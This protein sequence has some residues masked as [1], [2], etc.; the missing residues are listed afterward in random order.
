MTKEFN[1][2]DYQYVENVLTFDDWLR[3][4]RPQLN[5]FNDAARFD[6]LLYEHQDEQWEHVVSQPVHNLWTLFQDEA[7]VLKIK[8]GLVVRGRV[9][10]I[11]SEVQH[12]PL[13]TFMI[14][15]VDGGMLGGQDQGSELSMNVYKYRIIPATALDTYKEHGMAA[16]FDVETLNGELSITAPD[17]E[18]ADKMRMTYTDIRMWERI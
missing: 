12:N 13:Q 9:G 6:G 11:V 1:L 18:T 14:T 3:D 4:Y 16:T 15:D 10:Y 2:D 8:N 7:G 5:T 17:E